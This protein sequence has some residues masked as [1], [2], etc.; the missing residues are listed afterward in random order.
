MTGGRA[1][2]VR[3]RFWALLTLT[4]MLVLALVLISQNDYIRRQDEAIRELEDQREALLRGNEKLKSQIDY[5]YTD[6]YIIRE[7][8]EKL[9]LLQSDEILFESNGQ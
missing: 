3:P 9:G 1:K 8:R 7:A 2:T 4:F 5:T 6:E